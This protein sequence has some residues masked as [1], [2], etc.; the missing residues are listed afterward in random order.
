MFEYID[1]LQEELSSF[2]PLSPACLRRL[3]EDFMIKYT[4]DS[5]AIEGSTLTHDETY[6]V[7]KEGVT[8]S[9][10]P[11]KDHLDAVGH[12]DAYYYIEDLVK[13]KKSLDENVIK[14]IHYFAFMSGGEER[15]VYRD[16]QNYVGFFTPCP[17]AEVSHRMSDLIHKY[18]NDYCNMHVIERAAVFHLAFEAIHPFVD[19]N[20][21]TGR[22]LLNFELMKNGLP[23][24]NVKFTDKLKYLSAF[25]FFHDN[26]ENPKEMIK[27]V[28]EYSVQELNRYVG[29]YKEASRL[30]GGVKD[31]RRS[32]E[33]YFFAIGDAKVSEGVVQLDSPAR[34]A[35]A[36]NNRSNH[37]NK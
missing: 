11:L 16:V 10:K 30:N 5:N 31:K 18:N 28:Y 13:G 22:L 37:H 15:G 1:I 29:I 21:R 2:R 24:I 14:K 32:Q 35:S 4:Y 20:G 23:P 27:L 17:P 36:D 26:N 3:S 12:R 7:I 25:S 9:G 34:S 6:I 33:E 8:V 19:G